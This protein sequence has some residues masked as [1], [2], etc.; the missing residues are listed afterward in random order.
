MWTE[1]LCPG[2]A[3]TDFDFFPVFG[4]AELCLE[5]M[6]SLMKSDVV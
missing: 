2:G 4:V 5:A 1:I 3:K 6:M